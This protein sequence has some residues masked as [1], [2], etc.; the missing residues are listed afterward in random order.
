MRVHETGEGGDHRASGRQSL[1]THPAQDLAR[2]AVLGC[3]EPEQH[4]LAADVVVEQREG[5]GR[6]RLERLLRRRRKGNSP[7]DRSARRSHRGEQLGAQIGEL[8]VERGEHLDREVAAL[9][10]EAEQ[11]VLGTDVVVRDR[12]GGVLRERN[13]F[14]CAWREARERPEAGMILERGFV[15]RPQ[16]RH[17]A[18]RAFE[19]VLA[20][21]RDGYLR[22]AHGFRKI[23]GQVHVDLGH[24]GIV[25]L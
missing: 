24:G 14:S 25:G 12:A 20:Y 22:V 19:R 10:D 8:D 15:G 17:V 21:G 4:V 9:I 13:R 18:N 5:F 1:D 16:R 2:H 11:E 6:G 7:R 23:V 3:D